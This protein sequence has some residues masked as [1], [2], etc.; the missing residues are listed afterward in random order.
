[1]RI[2]VIVPCYN[3]A[4]FVSLAIRSILDQ[5]HPAQEIIVV[6][7]GS[8]DGT[9]EVLTSFSA[10][11]TLRQ[12]VHRGVGAALNNGIACASGEVIAF[13]DADDLWVRNKLELQT[14]ALN[15]WP[16]LDAVFGYARNFLDRDSDAKP[17]SAD[18]Y[19]GP[20]VPGFV[21]GTML[22]RRDFLS[23]VGPFIEDRQH[24][25][26][27]EWYARA[28]A[29]GFRWT[30]LRDLVHFRRVHHTNLGVRDKAQQNEDYL[31]ILRDIIRRRRMQL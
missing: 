4:P 7:D 27:L 17:P 9:C 25:D 13:L 3:V 20:P 10:A 31:A 19:L 5:T 2:S 14:K 21:R 16:E 11:V 29:T 1:V 6:D 8:T 23:Q 22:V 26:F 28:S 24:G 18:S 15:E 12:Q 30:M